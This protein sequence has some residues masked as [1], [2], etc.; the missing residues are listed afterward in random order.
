MGYISSSTIAV[1]VFWS[2]AKASYMQLSMLD[3]YLM[4]KTV[5]WLVQPAADIAPQ[6]ATEGPEKEHTHAELLHV[7]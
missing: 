4:A 5:G 6:A 7:V 3:L 1:P 2:A